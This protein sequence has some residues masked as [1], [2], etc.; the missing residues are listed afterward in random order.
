MPSIREFGIVGHWPATEA[1]QTSNL[2]PAPS[3]ETGLR[4]S[5]VFVF[6]CG[7]QGHPTRGGLHVQRRRHAPWAKTGIMTALPRR[8]GC[9]PIAHE[10]DSADSHTRWRCFVFLEARRRRKRGRRDGKM[11]AA[12]Y[13]CGGGGRQRA[14]PSRAVGGELVR[15]KMRE[16]E[17]R[18]PA[19]LV[20]TGQMLERS[21][22]RASNGGGV[23]MV[24][25]AMRYGDGCVSVDNLALFTKRFGYFLFSLPEY[26]F[27]TQIFIFGTTTSHLIKIAVKMPSDL[28]IFVATHPSKSRRGPSRVDGRDDNSSSAWGFTRWVSRETP[29][30]KPNS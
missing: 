10:A 23:R 25:K 2:F 3:G 22:L 15:C 11:T 4:D 26:I 6:S 8:T 19:C 16:S 30:S 13:P 24:Y 20:E 9:P 14:R 1:I 28:P 12:A 5:L 7:W 27:T 18:T 17:K 29:V 21:M